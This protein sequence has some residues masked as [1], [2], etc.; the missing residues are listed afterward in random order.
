MAPGTHAALS[1]RAALRLS[2]AAGAVAAAPAG[3]FAQTDRAPLRI[4]GPWEIA[5]LAPAS[6]GFVFTRLQ[7][8]ETLMDAHDD[9][10]P[11]PGLAAR[12]RV[13]DDGLAWRFELRPG[14]VVMAG[15]ATAAVAVDAGARI[16]LETQN[17]ARV[18]FTLSGVA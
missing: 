7:V 15:G 13:S 8:A 16:A 6:S 2:L 14:D 17:L 3:A 12:W 4:V 10:T 1:R 11:L 18:Q 9:G 5:G